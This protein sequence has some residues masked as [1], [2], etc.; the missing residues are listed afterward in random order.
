M[1][2]QKFKE[3]LLELEIEI[4]AR[5]KRDTA[6]GRASTLDTA[7]DA[8]DKSV[9]DE[10][11]S[12]AF[13][14][15]ELDSNVLAQVRD[16]LLRIVDGT[17]GTCLVDGEPIEAKRLEAVPWNPYCLKHQTLLEAATQLRTPTL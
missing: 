15:A 5:T 9:A 17:F 12:E 1:N 7:G 14:E 11:G 2:I 13:A 8:G 6:R 10:A 4:S 16:A 3:Q